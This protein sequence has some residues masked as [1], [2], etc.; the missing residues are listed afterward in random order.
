KCG[1]IPRQRHLMH[2]LDRQYPDWQ[3]YTMH[4]SSP[5]VDFLERW[6]PGYSSSQL[7]EDVPRGQ[8]MNGVRCEDL[9]QL[10]FAAASFDLFV[11]QDVLEHVFEP[12][13]VLSQIMRVLRPGGAHVFTT[14]KHATRAMSSAR[15]LR[16]NDGIVHLK[17]PEYHGN[18]V[19]DGRSLVTWD[20]GDDFETL[21]WR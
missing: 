16:R 13:V 17:E 19:G 6:C 21:I 12:G 11:T 4:E 8:V 10:T 15:C 18:P 20:Y 3:Q 9:E 5:S 7:I 14:P 1:S 2:V